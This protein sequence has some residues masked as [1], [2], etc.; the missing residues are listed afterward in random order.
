M[1]GSLAVISGAAT[2]VVS[3]SMRDAATAVV[4]WSMRDTSSLSS[5]LLVSD[6][7]SDSELEKFRALCVGRVVY[8]VFIVGGGGGRVASDS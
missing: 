3:W 6:P 4:S 8:S 2:A 5:S 7:V 1:L